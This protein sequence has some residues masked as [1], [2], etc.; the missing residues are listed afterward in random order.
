VT[1]A[2]GDA[3]A[4]L[5]ALREAAAGLGGREFRLMEVCGGQ[6]HAIARHGL[7]EL[8]P[9]GMKFLHGPGC[10][11]CVTP[12]EYLDRA[13][14][15]ARGERRVT[16]CSFGDLWRV[17][18]G[19]SGDLFG[20]K[21]AGADVRMVGSPL[22]ALEIAKAEPGREVVFLAIGFE[23]TVPANALAVW[24]AREE[25]VANFSEYAS[26]F[27]VPPAL[28]A[29]C[30]DAA[31]APDAFL[32][33]GHVCAVAG[34]AP[35]RALAKELGRPIAVAGF[36]PAELLSAAAAAAR[37]AAAGRAE[38]FNA[39]PAVVREEGNPAGRALAER[40]FETCDREWRGLGVL[41]A[42][43]LRPREEF[44]AWDAER[45]FGEF[46][47]G[48]AGGA[49]GGD[50]GCPAAEVLLGRLEPTGCPFFGRECTPGAPKG[51]PM[52]SPEGACAAFYWNRR[53]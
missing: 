16:L 49:E 15:L 44:A 11:V 1:G 37:L 28:R 27:S 14:A 24:K 35:Y 46:L 41:K 9:P 4:A 50:G 2:G 22:E 34:A 21:A 8:L 33:A 51:A 13:I 39:Y 26:Q 38:M 10:P 23:T 31:W 48:D 40:V 7:D 52:V 25:G 47:A 20:A 17:P 18:S 36:T 45:K 32:A 12:A 5:E 19:R 42:S 29:I 3:R 53:G 43:G 30:A 6:T